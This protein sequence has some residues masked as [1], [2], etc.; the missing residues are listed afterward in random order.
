MLIEAKDFQNKVFL[1]LGS[2]LG[3]RFL[4]LSQAKEAI[5]K[6][7]GEIKLLSSLYESKAW[8]VEEQGDF[9]NQV[10][11]CNSLLSA[12]EVLDCCLSIEKKLGRKRKLRWGERTI[13]IDVL[14][15]NDDCIDSERLKVPHPAIQDRR[16]TLIPL[17]E[18]DANFVHPVWQKTHK[19]LLE[20]CSDNLEVI[21][22]P[23][24]N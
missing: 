1:L 17:V 11:V 3:D 18:L 15:Y 24:T 7:I 10:I 19:A 4:F 16:F 6:E 12:H 23:T 22:L 2:N 20:N 9:L 13:D 21:R 14:Y 5:A 8:G